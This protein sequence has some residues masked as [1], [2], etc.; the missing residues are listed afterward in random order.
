MRPAL[1]LAP[2]LTLAPAPALI[3]APASVPALVPVPW[4]PNNVAC[5]SHVNLSKVE[6]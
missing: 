1:V 6:I 3:P 2:A 5:N 4:F